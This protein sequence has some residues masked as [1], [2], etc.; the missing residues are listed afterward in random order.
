MMPP[1]NADPRAEDDAPPPRA[2]WLTIVE[3]LGLGLYYFPLR[4]RPRLL[5]GLAA[6]AWPD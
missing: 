6:V 3:L 4:R 5:L 2:N 1:A